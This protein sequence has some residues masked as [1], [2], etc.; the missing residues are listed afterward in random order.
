[1]EKRL[2]NTPNLKP[3]DKALPALEKS[4]ARQGARKF[5]HMNT[6][7]YEQIN[8]RIPKTTGQII[9]SNLNACDIICSRDIERVAK[10]IDLA[11]SPLIKALES[12]EELM[13]SFRDYGMSDDRRPALI[14]A[15]RESRLA[16]HRVLTGAFIP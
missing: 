15:L 4:E 1:M 5:N 2:S 9:A 6:E 10:Q 11:Q 7:T 16:L 14:G 12:C 13:S 8:T 3:P